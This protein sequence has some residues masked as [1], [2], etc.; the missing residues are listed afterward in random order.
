M[1]S[2][3]LIWGAGAIGGIVGAHLARAGEDVTF[4]DVSAPHVAAIR[5]KGLTIVSDV[6]AFSVEVPVFTPQELK[7]RWGLI[8]LAV[9]SQFTEMA[10]AALT[11]FLVPTGAVL[12]LQN[13]FGTEIIGHHVGRGRTYAALGS[14]A[15]DVLEPGVIRFGGVLELPI[16]QIDG[17]DA[18]ALAEIVML[19]RRFEP[20]TFA[21]ME[22][23]SYLWGKH[24]FNSITC[25]TAMASSPFRELIQRESLVPLWRGLVREVLAVSSAHGIRPRTM[26]LFTP[27]AFDKDAPSDVTPF[28][29]MPENAP[30]KITKPHSGMWRDLAIHKRGTEVH[31]LLIPIVKLGA[32]YGL[33]SPLLQGVVDIIAEIEQG[34][35]IQAD[36]NLVELLGRRG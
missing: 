13:G 8:M 26:D 25:A 22:I 24:C 3:I 20:K 9:K 28:A 10:C 16:G 12:S 30:G 19:M 11:Q 15:G 7:G 36:H 34:Q 23:Q 14:I 5:E 6:A 4:V 32:G 33:S 18:P 2:H 21:T 17:L 29:A 1:N 31:A 27:M 35:R